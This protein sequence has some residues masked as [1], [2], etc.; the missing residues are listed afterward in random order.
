MLRFSPHHLKSQAV[1]ARS[2]VQLETC[3]HEQLRR[4]QTERA[5]YMSEV[6]DCHVAL[7]PLNV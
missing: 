3:C 2:V 4:L 7:A 5:G 1:E 6:H